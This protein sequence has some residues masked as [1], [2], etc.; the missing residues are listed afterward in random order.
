LSEAIRRINIQLVTPAE[1]PTDAGA[2]LFI[3]D[4]GGE[5]AIE[6][7][8]ECGRPQLARAYARAALNTCPNVQI[9]Y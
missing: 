4:D 5:S 7:L 8:C 2:A 9:A 6:L 3:T 1:L